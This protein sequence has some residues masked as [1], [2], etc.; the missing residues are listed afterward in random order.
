MSTIATELDHDAQP[1][2]EQA[3]ES[4]RARKEAE[5]PLGSY[6]ALTAIFAGLCAAFAAW[7]RRSERSL[8]EHIGAAD[9]ALITIATHK[10]SRLITKDRVTSAL[11]HPFTRYQAD[12]GP[13]EV[14]EQ[15]RGTGMR[16]ALGELL[17]CP[18]CI[19]MWLAA[20]FTAALVVAPRPTRWVA[21]ALT[22]LF[23]SD[24]LQIAYKRAEQQL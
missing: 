17:I 24:L 20:A 6:T 5:R 16:L 18:Y 21:A 2:R 12:A 14:E 19:G 3:T 22:A 7:M 1:A 10:L 8:P 11:R 4:E 23:G 9:L 13:G 15:A